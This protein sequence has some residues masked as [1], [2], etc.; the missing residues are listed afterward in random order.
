MIMSGLEARGPHE[1]ELMP[2][3]GCTVEGAPNGFRQ[4]DLAKRLGQ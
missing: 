1:S 3:G 2:R 4:L